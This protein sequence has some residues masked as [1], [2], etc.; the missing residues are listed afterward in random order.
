MELI[1][2]GNKTAAN[3]FFQKAVDVTPR[4]AYNLIQVLKQEDVDYI[5]APYEA[6]AQMAFLS[7]NGFV[8][9]VI[10]ED[11]DL[12]PYGATK[13]LFK[14]DQTGQGKEIR[15]ENL[16]ASRDMDLRGWTQSMIRHMCIMAGCDYLE[17]LN[18]FGVKK[19]HTWIKKYKD[20]MERIFTLLRADRNVALPEDYETRFKQADLTFQHQRIYDP[21][22]K[23]IRPLSDFPSEFHGHEQLDFIGPHLTPEIGLGIATAILDPHSKQPFEQIIAAALGRLPNGSSAS[24]ASSTT[25]STA[26]NT[27][28][29]NATATP[30]GKM[31]LDAALFQRRRV[32]FGT[33]L[34]GSP[35]SSTKKGMSLPPSPHMKKL[36]MYFGKAF[37]PP[38]KTS[39]KDTQGSSQQ[40]S[41]VS[42]VETA[43]VDDIIDGEEDDDDVDL[44]NITRDSDDEYDGASL[45]A[46]AG[47][48]RVLIL[49]QLRLQSLLRT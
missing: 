16:D 43:S 6:D 30:A 15:R 38:S 46:F 35:A 18:G 32:A 39:G 4:M 25:T 36:D 7:M 42:Q 49:L 14:M 20:D 45:L 33:G 48:C 17:G 11:S 10:T 24:N 5:V 12:V 13:I 27:T 2:E 23:T 37:K 19:A 29:T 34:F 1:R 31:D 47:E 21:R 22:T 8:D 9:A 40:S 28:T 3:E 41:Q 44:S 26:A